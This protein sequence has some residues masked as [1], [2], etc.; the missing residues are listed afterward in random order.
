MFSRAGVFSIN[1]KE[2]KRKVFP[3]F[4]LF[5]MNLQNRPIHLNIPATQLMK[6]QKS[7]GSSEMSISRWP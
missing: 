7:G 6:I 2:K 4:L 3:D 1:E 5:Q